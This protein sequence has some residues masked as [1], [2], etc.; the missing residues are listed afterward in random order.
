[1][2]YTSIYI[3]LLTM[4]AD[5]DVERISNLEQKDYIV[6]ELEAVKKWECIINIESIF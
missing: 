5:N 2:V 3:Y 6:L 4:S 1:M